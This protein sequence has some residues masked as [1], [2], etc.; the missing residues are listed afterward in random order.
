MSIILL[1]AFHLKKKKNIHVYVLQHLKSMAV[2]PPGR[3]GAYSFI[4]DEKFY[5]YHGH[6]GRRDQQ[7][8]DVLPSYDLR[9]AEWSEVTTI[10]KAKRAVSGEAVT[11]VN[12]KLLAF[13]GCWWDGER[14]AVVWALDLKTL[15]WRECVPSNPSEGPMPKDKAGTVAYGDEMLCVF[16]GYGDMPSAHNGVIPQRGAQYHTDMTSPRGV[17]WTNELHLFHIE[18]CEFLPSSHTTSWA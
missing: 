16:G 6:N 2:E 7:R 5:L 18:N 10:N 14:S 9:T 3:R 13:G 4:H 8:E 11:L 12:D 15:G 17:C 1:H